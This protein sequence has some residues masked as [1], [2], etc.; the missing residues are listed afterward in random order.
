MENQQ[1][2]VI[3]QERDA[4]L[5]N[6]VSSQAPALLAQNDTAIQL[7]YPS[8][9]FIARSGVNPL[10]AAASALFALIAKLR[11]AEQ[12]NDI[13]QLRQDLVHEV[14]AFECAAVGRH[15]SPEQVLAARYV[16]CA[17]LDEVIL[18]TGW[19]QASDW[20]H[21]SLI[22]SF[23]D[24]ETTG[25]QVF[26]LLDRLRIKTKEYIDL[27]EFFYL[28]LSLGFEGKY[29]FIDNGRQSLDNLL[30][31][32]YRIIRRERGDRSLPLAVSSGNRFMPSLKKPLSLSLRRILITTGV[33]LALVYISFII[34]LHV[35]I[36]PVYQLLSTI[37]TG[38]AS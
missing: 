1:A 26:A 29:R 17:T 7:Y 16:M 22:K 35:E 5:A 3:E 4:F 30:D 20:L 24:D 6:L 37:T 13:I 23:N 14:K 31:D 2:L 33:I 38:A 10:A 8:K 18:L 11:H 15:Y 28:C 19:G 36:Q 34:M 32:L 9:T 21:N 25:E 27:I 12:Y